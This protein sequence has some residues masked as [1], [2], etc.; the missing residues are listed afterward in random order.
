MD[1]SAVKRGKGR[2][3]GRAGYYKKCWVVN[4]EIWDDMLQWGIRRGIEPSRPS[5]I[6]SEMVLTLKEI[7]RAGEDVDD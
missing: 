7:E 1:V 4:K 5:K 2:P 3:K 6:L